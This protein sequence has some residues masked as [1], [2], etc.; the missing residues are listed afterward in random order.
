V[1]Y[2]HLDLEQIGAQIPPK[3]SAFLALVEDTDAEAVVNSMPG[4]T[5]N[6]VS[7]TLGDELSGTIAQATK[8][9]VQ[10]PAQQTGQAVNV[11]PKR[12]NDNGN[13]TSD[14]QTRR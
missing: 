6:V 4:Y 14:L 1:W 9:E 11:A 5:T 2:Q 13:V 8:A 10:V 7:V 3:S 12:R